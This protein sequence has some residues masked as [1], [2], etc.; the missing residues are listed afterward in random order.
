MPFFKPEQWKTWKNVD[1][2]TQVI[3]DHPKTHRKVWSDLVLLKHLKG[4]E[5][6]G[7]L[8]QTTAGEREEFSLPGFY[9]RLVK[10]IASI[11]VVDCPELRDLLLFV[12]AGLEDEDIPHRIEMAQLIATR[13]EV[14]RGNLVSHL[15]FAAHY[16][17]RDASGYLVLKT[18]LVAFRRM[19][20]SHTSE[21]IGKVFV[22]VLKEIGCLH[23]VGMITCDNASD[24]NTGMVQIRDELKAIDIPF[25]EVSVVSYQ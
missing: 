14:D 15:A 12:G 22:Q 10:W 7:A 19:E 17:V 1:G 2:Q 16:I 24:N 13:L 9:E 23:K 18:P 6:I 21:N 20:G 5:T 4:W 3:R 25:R 11:D 8:T